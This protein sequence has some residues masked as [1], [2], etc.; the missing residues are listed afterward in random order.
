M[1]AAAP[2]VAAEPTINF[3]PGLRRAQAPTPPHTPKE[4]Y[5]S[6]LIDSV[7]D[8]PCRV[9]D[10]DYTRLA[11][12]VS[13]PGRSFFPCLVKE[14]FLDIAQLVLAEKHLVADEEGR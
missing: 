7:G 3:P 14:F 5:V 12:G 4:R 9:P 1:V 10:V 11:G 13:G 8:D 6:Q 2:V